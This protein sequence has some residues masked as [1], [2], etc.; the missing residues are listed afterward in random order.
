LLFLISYRKFLPFF[1]PSRHSL[2][3]VFPH[4]L[5]FIPSILA[6]TTQREA[7]KIHAQSLLHSGPGKR[8][9]MPGKRTRRVKKNPPCPH[10]LR[11]SH[12]KTHDEW[13][14]RDAHLRTQRDLH[15]IRS[16]WSSSPHDRFASTWSFSR[17]SIFSPWLRLPKTRTRLQGIHRKK[18]HSHRYQLSSNVFPKRPDL[19]ATYCSFSFNEYRHMKIAAE[20]SIPTATDGLKYEINCHEYIRNVPRIEPWAFDFPRPVR[21]PVSYFEFRFLVEIWETLL[22]TGAS[23]F[24]VQNGWP[25]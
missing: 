3:S 2:F 25:V 8:D 19:S 18:N 6:S 23:V 20:A 21:W 9:G 24:I 22:K 12:S 7:S 15:L 10:F 16:I 5:L 4:L 13:Y 11:W 1:L 17:L 14:K